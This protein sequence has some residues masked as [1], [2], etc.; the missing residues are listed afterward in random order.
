MSPEARLSLRQEKRRPILDQFHHWL[1]VNQARTFV[2]ARKN[3]LFAC[4]PQG[5]DSLGAQVT[6]SDNGFTLFGCVVRIYSKTISVAVNGDHEGPWR[7][8][9]RLLSLLKNAT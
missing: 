8:S 4:T 2:I 6:F 3:F 9:P 1:T 5:A 7:V